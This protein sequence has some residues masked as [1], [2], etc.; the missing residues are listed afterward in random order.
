MKVMKSREW[1]G[2]RYVVVERDDG[3]RVEIRGSLDMTDTA[4]MEKCPT[5]E[6][7]IEAPEALGTLPMSDDDLLKEV[8]KRNLTTSVIA[9]ATK[10]IR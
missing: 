9:R 2:C 1:N 3:T 5:C 10:C 8:D 6:P 7:E 4:A